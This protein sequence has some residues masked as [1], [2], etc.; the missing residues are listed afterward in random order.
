MIQL[1]DIKPISLYLPDDPIWV[2]RDR[3]GKEYF[4][5]Q[6]LEN[7]AWV[8]GIHAQKMGVQ[9]R[10]IYLLDN[11]PEEQFYIG[12][13][14]LGGFLSC[15]SM[16]NVMNNLP[17][18]HFMFLETDCRFVDGWRDKLN[19]E[20]KNVPEDFDFLFVGSCCAADKE[21]V[22]IAGN[23]Y[24]FPFRGDDKWTWYPQ[25]GH[26]MVIAKKAVP[27]VLETC[28]DTANPFDV[29]LIKY[30]FPKLKVYAILPRLATQPQ[31]THL[32][33]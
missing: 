25:C 11:R 2:E 6:G 7:I 28:N 22:H 8:R 27:V 30:A 17:D 32:A 23:I 9:G 24:E 1:S 15:I 10:H 13:A 19:E 18:S 20:L 12:D 3:E 4:I 31:L 33:E 14:K 21:P 26:C 5:S 29:A 16:Y